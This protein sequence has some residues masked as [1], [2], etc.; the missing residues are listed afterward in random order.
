[1]KTMLIWAAAA[2]LLA[3]V[4]CAH[5]DPTPPM[6]PA[7]LEQTRPRTDAFFQTLRSGDPAKAYRDLFAGTLLETTKPLR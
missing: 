4:A 5:D 3:G 2:S 6:S 7:S 1:M